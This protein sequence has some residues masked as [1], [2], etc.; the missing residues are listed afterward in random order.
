MSKERLTVNYPFELKFDRHSGEK[1]EFFMETPWVDDDKFYEQSNVEVI[2]DYPGIKVIKSDYDNGFKMI[3]I[4]TD[5]YYI[6]KTNWALDKLED[7]T[8]L[9][10][11][12]WPLRIFS[13]DLPLI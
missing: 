1:I 5:K 3:L 8:Y 10:R 4:E 12:Q 7:G 13:I 11:I 2:A 6:L 9:P